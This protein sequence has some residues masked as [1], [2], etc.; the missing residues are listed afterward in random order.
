MEVVGKVTTGLERAIATSNG[1]IHLA[2]HQAFKEPGG[3][4]ENALRTGYRA[5][6]LAPRQQL[7]PAN[8]FVVN[9]K[10]HY[11]KTPA[12]QPEP[13]SDY[14]YMLLHIEGRKEREDWRMKNIV[15]R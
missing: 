4:G 5:V 13:I 10:L 6:V 3:G 9:E 12:A 8:F 11:R 14:E 1:R 7:E 15:E 2:S